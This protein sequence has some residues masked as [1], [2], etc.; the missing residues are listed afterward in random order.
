MIRMLSR[1]SIDFKYHTK[2]NAV[3]HEVV[4]QIFVFIIIHTITNNFQ[5]R[6]L[7]DNGKEKP[8]KNY[9]YTFH[10]LDYHLFNYIS[11]NHN[12]ILT[13]STYKI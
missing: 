10:L 5:C 11:S 4:K 13:F 12:S 6:L 2:T 7:K 9:S 1:D 8:E 3:G